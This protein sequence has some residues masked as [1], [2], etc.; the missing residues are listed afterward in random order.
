MLTWDETKRQSNL[1][2]HGLDFAHAALVLESPW[3]MDVDVVRSYEL[4]TQSLAYV[5]DHLRVLT[6]VH[7]EREGAHR[8]ISF[9]RASAQEREAYHEWLDG[10][11]DDA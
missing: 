3:R 1:A 2:K 5:V 6:V 8:V 9:R 4:R 11:T 10:S 7:T